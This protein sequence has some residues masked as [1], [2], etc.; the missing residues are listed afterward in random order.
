MR[1]NKYLYLITITYFALGFVNIHFALLGLICMAI[2]FYLLQKNKKKTWCQGYCPRASLYTTVGKHKKN[3]RKTPVY[4][5]KGNMKKIV[6]AYF[7]VSLTVILMSTLG[8]A[9]GRIPPMD[10]L[11]FL[12]VFKLPVD[13]PQIIEITNLAPWV[14][15]LAYRF[16]SMMMTT[17]ILGLLLALI[18]KPRTWCTICPVGTLSDEYLK[19]R[20]KVSNRPVIH[21]NVEAE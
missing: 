20:K 21:K 17:S 2:P 13:L 5:T 19:S 3:S 16:Y 4:F 15:H 14:T 10:Y 12:L 9:I 6:L 7:F 18:Y 11:R 8:V 1:N